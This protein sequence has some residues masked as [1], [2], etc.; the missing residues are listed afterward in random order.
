MHNEVSNEIKEVP[1]SVTKNSSGACVVNAGGKEYTPPEVSAMVLQK[2]NNKPKN[3]LEL[4]QLMR[5]LL[6]L[7][8]LMILKDKRPRMLERLLG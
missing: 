6:F 2:L 5:S 4:R 7:H 8:I 3:T 1:Y